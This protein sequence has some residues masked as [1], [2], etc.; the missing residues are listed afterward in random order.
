[1]K[2]EAAKSST[3]CKLL[4]FINQPNEKPFPPVYQRVL[5]KGFSPALSHNNPIIP[6]ERNHLA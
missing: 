4:Q 6:S 3:D 2:Y 5:G 1:V